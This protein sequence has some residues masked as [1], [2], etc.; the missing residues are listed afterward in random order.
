M[1]RAMILELLEQKPMSLEELTLYTKFQPSKIANEIVNLYALD[2][3]ETY[4]A[5][6]VVMCKLTEKAAQEDSS[7]KST[8]APALKFK[9][10][11]IL[12]KKEIEEYRAYRKQAGLEDKIKETTLSVEDWGRAVDT[13]AGSMKL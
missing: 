4:K 10:P 5:G 8:G 3:V 1:L 13:K 2:L 9:V 11:K 7:G 12:T 6:A